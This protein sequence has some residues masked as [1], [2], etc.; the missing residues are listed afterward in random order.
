MLIALFI[1]ATLL[2]ILGYL[3]SDNSGETTALVING[4][5][6]LACSAGLAVI[7]CLLLGSHLNP[8]AM[9]VVRVLCAVGLAMTGSM[10]VW[11]SGFGQKFMKAICWVTCALMLA[12]ILTA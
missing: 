11:S 2:L 4:V 10:A 3:G 8:T 12:S 1:L 6:S 7:G 5:M 9:N